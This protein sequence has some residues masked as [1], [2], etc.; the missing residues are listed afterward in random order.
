M[1]N[2]GNVSEVHSLIDRGVQLNAENFHPLHNS[3]AQ[4]LDG[5]MF[6]CEIWHLKFEIKN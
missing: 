2:L 3:I 4:H 6:E 1:N 5:S